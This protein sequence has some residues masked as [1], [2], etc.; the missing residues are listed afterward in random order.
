V[1]KE[2]EG[3]CDLQIVFYEVAVVSCKSEE[4]ADFCDVLGGKPFPYFFN[5]DVI[6]VYCSLSHPYS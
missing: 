2:E 4:F 3:F 5:F 6:H 1:G